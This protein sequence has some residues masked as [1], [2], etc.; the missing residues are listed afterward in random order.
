M[1]SSSGDGG[2]LTSWQATCC[3]VLG[4]GPARSACTDTQ[5][6][7]WLETPSHTHNQSL[8][9][10]VQPHLEEEEEAESTKKSQESS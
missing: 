8:A 6:W 3:A 1:R 2:V 7:L 5:P 9:P 4:A 10:D